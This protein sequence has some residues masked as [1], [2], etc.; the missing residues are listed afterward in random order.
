MNK[1]VL[2]ATS[3]DEAP[4]PGYVLNEIARLTQQ[5][6]EASDKLEDFLFK[7]LKKEAYTQVKL[8]T[9]RVIKYCCENGH[10][11]F[12]RRIQRRS[13]D[14]REFF[15]EPP[16]PSLRHVFPREQLGDQSAR[17]PEPPAV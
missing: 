12:R 10:I 11:S 6:G 16:D 2:Q 8:K 1:L 15:G 7:R 14:L 4:A 17:R 13:A 5:S 3:K 9:L